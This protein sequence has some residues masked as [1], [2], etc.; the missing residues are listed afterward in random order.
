MGTMYWI[1]V[2]GMIAVLAAVV[3]SMRQLN[4]G[5]TVVPTTSGPLSLCDSRITWAEDVASGTHL[6]EHNRHWMMT[7]NGSMMREI[8][9][10][11]AERWFSRLCS[12]K[13][14]VT[15]FTGDFK[16]ALKLGYVSGTTTEV[17]R[18]AANEFKISTETLRSPDLEE[19]LRTLPNLPEAAKPGA[20]P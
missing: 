3:W 10:A 9:G 8:D 6:E 11:E 19:A 13:L 15:K 14:E 4:Q 12:A 5:K 17:S 7:V 2:V 20:H 18:A 16:P 1:R